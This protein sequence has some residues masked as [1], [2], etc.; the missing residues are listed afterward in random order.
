[1]AL[2]FA[3]SWFVLLG[4]WNIIVAVMYLIRGWEWPP[5]MIVPSRAGGRTR[6]FI[7]ILGTA[8]IVM[9]LLPYLTG[10]SADT[11]NSLRYAA[12]AALGIYVPLS[13]RKPRSTSPRPEPDEQK[14]MQGKKRYNYWG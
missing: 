13:L 8:I 6:A 12:L 2:R 1:V 11:R 9:P 10:W 14:G 7:L 5:I 3:V 4:L